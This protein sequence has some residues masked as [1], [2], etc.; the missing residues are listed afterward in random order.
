MSLEDIHVGDT[1]GE[2]K[3]PDI[4]KTYTTK[5]VFINPENKPRSLS[6]PLI[7]A[8]DITLLKALLKSAMTIVVK[9]HTIS[10]AM[11]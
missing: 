5:T 11:T 9:S 2:S 7:L 3:K 6:V 10:I 4:K 1:T 8:A